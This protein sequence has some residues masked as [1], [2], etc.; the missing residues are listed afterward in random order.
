MAKIDE[1]KEEIGAL[2]TYLGFLVA[3]II[4]TVAGITK[5]YIDGSSLYMLIVGVISVVIFSSIFASFIVT[6]SQLYI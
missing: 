2:K 1:V 4:S 5:L 6:P 3:F